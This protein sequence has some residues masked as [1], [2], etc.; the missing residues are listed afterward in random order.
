MRNAKHILA[1][2]RVTCVKNT[3][4]SV[5]IYAVNA[6]N[7]IAYA[8]LL[9]ARTATKSLADVAKNAENILAPA[10]LYVRNAER[11]LANVR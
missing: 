9:S 3:L 8:R 5:I 11:I 6:A 4:V 1:Y 2:V 7:W 10:R